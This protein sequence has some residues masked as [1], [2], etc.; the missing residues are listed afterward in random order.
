MKSHFVVNAALA[1]AC[2]VA[3]GTAQAAQADP[4]R[5]EKLFEECRTCHSVERGVH[6]I[7]PSLNG[8]LGRKAGALDDFRFSP[9]LKRSDITWSRKSL[10]DFIADPQQAVPANRMPYS[11]MPDGR[12]RADV[13]EY[14]LQVLK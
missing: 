6:G 1:A 9:A 8:V 3:Y 14:M 11:G 13:I 2:L 12:N 4:K 7:G 10:D 5:G